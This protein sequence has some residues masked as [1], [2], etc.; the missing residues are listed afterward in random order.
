[1][2]DREVPVFGSEGLLVLHDCADPFDE[3]L[4]LALDW[5]LFLVTGCSCLNVDVVV[6]VE[7]C[8]QC[9]VVF[10]G[11]GVAADGLD[12]VAVSG[13]EGDDVVRTRR[14]VVADLSL[15]MVQWTYPLYLSRTM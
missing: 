6:G 15:T 12:C 9:I 7:V 14:R 11:S 5:I 1:M 3:V 4:D 13:V 8:G 2:F 10:R